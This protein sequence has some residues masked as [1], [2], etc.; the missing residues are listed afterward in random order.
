MGSKKICKPD[1]ENYIFSEGIDYSRTG[2]VSI[3]GKGD[4]DMLNFLL[5]TEI[6][7]SWLNLAAGDGRYSS[8]LLEKAK[9][10]ISC[11]IDESAL[12]KLRRNTPEKFRAKLCTETFDITRKFPFEDHYFDGIFCSGTLHLFPKEVLKKIFAEMDRVL[13][14]NGKVIIDFAADITRKSPEGNLI[15]FGDEPL[16]TMERAKCLLKSIFRNYETNMFESE[17]TEDY[18]RANPPY[19]LDCKFVILSGKKNG[20]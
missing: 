8:I 15:T 10:V 4:P 2:D 7:G 5:G 12:C 1:D 19:R 18:E 17:V 20:S 6:S 9:K 13:K 16:Y 11:D 3:W 14:P